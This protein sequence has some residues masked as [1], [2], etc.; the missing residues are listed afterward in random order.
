MSNVDVV[1]IDGEAEVSDEEKVS[2]PAMYQV[3]IFN[4]DYTPIDIVA[5][6]L[7][8]FFGMNADVAKKVTR[9][10]HS[11]GKAR[12]GIFTHEIAETKSKMINDYAQSIEQ[13]LLS[14]IEKV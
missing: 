5:E 12:C 10:A 7:Q 3:I 14:A 6:T 11:S 4:D 2:K 1:V 8:R 13:P 9:E